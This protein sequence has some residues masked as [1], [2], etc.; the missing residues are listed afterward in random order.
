M[1]DKAQYNY[2]GWYHEYIVLQKLDQTL[3]NETDNRRKKILP[4]EDQKVQ[5]FTDKSRD[6]FVSKTYGG[7]GIDKFMRQSNTKKKKIHVPSEIK[8]PVIRLPNLS[9]RA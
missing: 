9:R 6:Q 4:L 8:L 3:A 7:V 2:P 5:Q 1:T